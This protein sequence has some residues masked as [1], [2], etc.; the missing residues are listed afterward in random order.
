MKRIYLI[1]IIFSLCL[2]SCDKKEEKKEVPDCG[3][4]SIYEEIIS[5]NN[6]IGGVLVFAKDKYTNYYPN[7]Y[8]LVYKPTPKHR[9]IVY[10]ICNESFISEDLKRQAQFL[11]TDEIRV[12]VY[13]SG[14]MSHAEAPKGI[15]TGFPIYKEVTLTKIKS[16]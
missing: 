8:R 9:T 10:I 13:F 3:C 1:F 16:R 15:S 11:T 14:Y 5:E 12:P 6:P 2:Y 4:E 7:T